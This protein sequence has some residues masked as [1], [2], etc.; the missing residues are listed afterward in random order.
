MA[1]NSSKLQLLSVFP[2]ITELWKTKIA[3]IEQHSEGLQEGLTLIRTDSI[4]KIK[5]NR[6][7]QLINQRWLAYLIMTNYLLI[8]LK[9]FYSFARVKTRQLVNTV[10]VQR[11][12]VDLLPVFLSCCQGICERIL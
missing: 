7:D 3:S 8:I 5:E 4:I 1:G 6:R 2:Q 10:L 11:S 12:L 9:R